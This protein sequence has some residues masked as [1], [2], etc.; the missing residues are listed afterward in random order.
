[1]FG[2]PPIFVSNIFFY[3]FMKKKKIAYHIDNCALTSHLLTIWMSHLISWKSIYCCRSLINAA[4]V[5]ARTI[6]Q[7]D[8]RG[9][10]VRRY[11]WKIL[12]NSQS[13]VRTQ[14]KHLPLHLHVSERTTQIRPI[15]QSWLDQIRYA[16]YPFIGFTYFL[17]DNCFCIDRCL[18]H[19][20]HNIWEN[21]TKWEWKHVKIHLSYSVWKRSRCTSY[22]F[23]A[24]ILV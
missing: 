15:Q 20:S 16:S 12:W 22:H 3:H 17:W 6:G 5:P 14:E 10:S 8:G 23:Y 24:H 7:P 9:V 2:R 18:V 19:F 13:A 11:I 4:W 1:M 21:F